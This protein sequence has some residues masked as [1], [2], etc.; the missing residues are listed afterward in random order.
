MNEQLSATLQAAQGGVANIPADA[1]IT[2][3][4]TWHSALS[5]VPGAETLVDHLAQLKSALESGN[6]QQAAGLLPGLG[7]ETEKLAQNA[8]EADKEGLRQL[9]AALK[10]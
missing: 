7:S 8:P 10:G 1:A 5:G 2:N 4:T 6:L 3:V 9:A